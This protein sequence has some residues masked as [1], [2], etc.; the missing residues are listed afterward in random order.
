M[1][2][3]FIKMVGSKELYIDVD[4]L[5]YIVKR[6]YA[7]DSVELIKS[8]HRIQEKLNIPK[9][10]N[11]EHKVDKI[12]TTEQFITGSTIQEL[13]DQGSFIN[14]QQFEAYAISLVKTLIELH[15]HDIIHKDIKPANVVISG[16]EVYIIDFNIS[17]TFKPQQNKDTQLFG[18]EGY[19]SPE[20]YGFSQTT[21]KSDIYSLG[22]TLADLMSITVVEAEDFDSYTELFKAMS[23]LDPKD[24]ISLE[25]FL[26]KIGYKERRSIKS[27]IK[28]SNFIGLIQA[29]GG[30][31]PSFVASLFCFAYG[32]EFI[33]DYDFPEVLVPIIYLF[34]YYLGTIVANIVISKVTRPKYKEMRRKHGEPLIFRWIGMRTVEV[35]AFGLAVSATLDILAII[36]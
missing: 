17:R 4:T 8:L 9:I 29:E 25:Q 35:V 36:M 19:A 30:F 6:E 11:V 13:I 1:N 32:Q 5:Q 28:H 3:Q 33:T 31:F 34:S 7:P 12:I 23:T 21:T 20:Q 27:L 10:L 26:Q 24:R 15:K 18:T 14:K 22:K 16:D 2:L